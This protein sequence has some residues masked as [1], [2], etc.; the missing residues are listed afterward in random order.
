MFKDFLNLCICENFFNSSV[1]L[2]DLHYRIGHYG[3]L[4]LSLLFFRLLLLLVS[5][6]IEVRAHKLGKFFKHFA[7][8]RI[9]PI[10]EH[11]L[12]WVLPKF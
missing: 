9:R 2:N 7:E 12:L 4:F 6:L 5:Y 10:F 8:F 1:A 11:S 3:L